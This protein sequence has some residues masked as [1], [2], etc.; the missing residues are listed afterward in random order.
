MLT[1]ILFGISL[2]MVLGLGESSGLDKRASLHHAH[3]DAAW[4]LGLPLPD[5]HAIIRRAFIDVRSS[6]DE[7]ANHVQVPEAEL[8]EMLDN[9]KHLEDQIVGMLPPEIPENSPQKLDDGTQQPVVDNEAPA[10][11]AMK[12]SE[13]PPLEAPTDSQL[14]ANDNKPTPDLSKPDRT[15]VSGLGNDIPSLPASTGNP[16]PRPPPSPA[17][18]RHGHHHHHGSPIHQLGANPG[19]IFKEGPQALET[20]IFTST[21]TIIS[22][23]TTSYVDVITGTPAPEP[24]MTDDLVQNGQEFEVPNLENIAR[25]PTGVPATF[26]ALNDEVA[27]ISSS[28]EATLADITT[29]QAHIEQVP[30]PVPVEVL[31]DADPEQENLPVVPEPDILAAQ[32][33]PVDL[34]ESSMLLSGF[35]TVTIPSTAGSKRQIR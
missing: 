15:D 19:A 5:R 17:Q 35:R 33:A 29:D 25:E 6:I 14:D 12:L 34:P 13:H 8:H 7:S 11:P 23:T 4:G 16:G 28:E 22:T 9:I 27:P 31:G 32:T 2:P 3:H 26:F 10:D 30:T 21:M 24:I 18:G 1:S 20:S